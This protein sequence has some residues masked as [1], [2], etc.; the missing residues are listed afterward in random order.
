MFNKKLFI[1]FFI[2]SLITI[3]IIFVIVAYYFPYELKILMDSLAVDGSFEGFSLKHINIVKFFGY[4]LIITG[5]LTFIII[6]IAHLLRFNV[7]KYIPALSIRDFI[8][9]PGNIKAF[10]YEIIN[11]IRVAFANDDRMH[12]YI[13][14]LLILSAVV[15]RGVALSGPSSA[16][17]TNILESRIYHANG[18]MGLINLIRNYYI[19]SDHVFHTILSYLSFKTIGSQKYIWTLRMPAFFAGILS[20]PLIYITVRMFFNKYAALFATGILAASSFHIHYSTLARGYSMIFLFSLI[21]LALGAYVI[22]KNNLA[23]YHLIAIVSSLGFYTIPTMLYPYGTV[24]AWLILSIIFND[25]NGRVT[26]LKNICISIVVTIVMT[27]ILYSPI[28]FFG[29]G[30]KSLYAYPII[31]PDNAIPLTEYFK[32]LSVQLKYTWKSWNIGI[33]DMLVYLFTLA[34]LTVHVFHKKLSFYRAP[35]SLAAVIFITPLLSIQRVYPAPQHLIFLLIIYIMLVSGGLVL[36]LKPLDTYIRN[37]KSV[38][39]AL[40]A[41]VLT[42]ILIY[43]YEQS[44]SYRNSPMVSPENSKSESVDFTYLENSINYHQL[45]ELYKMNLHPG[46]YYLNLPKE[47]FGVKLPPENLWDFYNMPKT[48][49]LF[50]SPEKTDYFLVNLQKSL[51]INVRNIINSDFESYLSKD[52][53]RCHTIFLLSDEPIPVMNDHME[54][55]GLPVYDYS[56]PQLIHQFN[57]VNLYMV[58]R[59]KNCIENNKMEKKAISNVY[60]WNVLINIYKDKNSRF[61]GDSGNDGLIGN[62]PTEQTVAASAIGEM[63]AFD[64]MPTIPDNSI[65]IGRYQFWIYVGYDSSNTNKNVLVICKTVN[66]SDDN[67]FTSD[68]LK[69]IE[70]IDTAIDGIDDGGLGQFRASTRVILA[71]NSLAIKKRYTTAVVTDVTAID[72]SSAGS[73]TA[74]SIA[75]NSAVWLFDKPY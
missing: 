30:L 75:H 22:R 62:A 5:S 52:S 11:D 17:E 4:F 1:S 43:S 60:N 21:T 41:V 3:G 71:P 13:L 29:T 70:A 56:K 32:N 24:I 50:A 7:F 6:V 66:C 63:A 37:N 31:K 47:L 58:K 14:I 54:G 8:I 39:Y 18:L 28:L 67:K 15:I 53:K 65:T 27:F 48:L 36:L 10:L 44:G 42:M 49:I 72:E 2:S 57:H 59:E 16:D 45:A 40:L 33:P 35:L 64:N 20:L 23:G 12:R 25:V 9:S 26:C 38:I 74:W 19:P 51:H 46:L 61:P 34:L 68:E 69:L 55:M 73:S